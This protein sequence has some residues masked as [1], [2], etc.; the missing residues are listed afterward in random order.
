MDPFEVMAE[1]ARRRIV[2]ILASGEH[3]SGQLA[4]VVGGELRIS[5]SAVSKHLRIL[6]E[7]GFV[8]VRVEMSW[9][10]YWLL[11]DAISL[12]ESSVRDIREKRDAATGWDAEHGRE[13]DPLAVWPKYERTMDRSESARSRGNGKGRRG[14]QTEAPRGSDP[15]DAFWAPRL[16]A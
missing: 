16:E 15:E 8:G 10:I 9:R 11:D 5:R 13:Y 12:L 2:D 4:E 14:R 7:A 1:P 3:A 6:R